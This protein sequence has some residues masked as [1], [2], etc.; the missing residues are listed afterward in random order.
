MFLVKQLYF[1]WQR[2]F[3]A[4]LLVGLTT[5]ASH[6]QAL[7]WQA[8]LGTAG[9][10]NARVNSI[11][12]DGSGNLIL[13]G[14]FN[15]Q[16]DLG[17]GILLAGA[18]Q[19]DA[20]VA[21]WSP[22]TQQFVWGVQIGGTLGDYVEDVAVQGNNLY[23]TG[24]FNSPTITLGSTTLTR[25]SA[26]G[27]TNT[28]GDL[29]IAKLVDAGS[30]ASF[31]WALGAGGPADDYAKAVAVNGTSVY[32]AGYFRSSRIT[33]GTNPI[34]PNFSYNNL[35]DGFV[36]KVT[37]AGS[38]ASFTWSQNMGGTS[39]D[40]ANALVVQGNNVYVAGYLSATVNVANVGGILTPVVGASDGFVA[41]VVDSGLNNSFAWV[42]T[43]AGPA[44]ESINDLKL[45][46]GSLYA[47]GFFSGS[48]LTLGATTLTNAGPA[49]TR[50]ALVFK[51]TDTGTSASYGWAKSAGGLDYDYAQ[52]VAVNGAD[53]Y[54]VG[55]FWSPSLVVG[56]TTLPSAG[57][58]TDAWVAR[59]TDAGPSSSFSGAIRGGGPGEDGANAVLAT[60]TGAYVGG[61]A[62]VPATFGSLSLTS[63][64]P[65]QVG[66]LATVGNVVLATRPATALA[67]SLHPNPALCRTTSLTG[68]LPGTV[69]AVLDA[70]G[71]P[72]TSATADAVGTAALTL[73]AGLS[74]GIY[75]VRA[76][77]QSLRL[78][79][80]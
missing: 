44:E 48:S 51:L 5:M 35:L 68:A 10:H 66:V 57:G 67:S 33:F 74:A 49:N 32:L 16:L 53:V 7:G 64:A 8:V 79:V 70:L 18:F 36:A 37:D 60:P 1:L 78:A 12:A 21:K 43:T 38:S 77:T 54:V 31:V 13:G 71:R 42:K 59:L 65:F 39:T 47:A 41:K 72:I 27:T 52:G 29:F 19:H 40:V 75:V 4:A 45:S 80:E 63:P 28:D 17:N 69:V 22:T 9:Q 34:I 14:Y 24:G 25:S 11:T 23:V 50:D 76:G 55:S 26:A 15:G 3:L 62:A 46:N 56:T 2:G 30:S 61:Y 20:F 6:A 73:P 58:Y